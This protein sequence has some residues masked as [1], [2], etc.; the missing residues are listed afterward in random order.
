MKDRPANVRH[1]A[2][3]A[4]TVRHGSLTQAARAVNLT[5]PALSQ[6]ISALEAS[7]DVTLFKRGTAGMIPTE[8]ALQLASRAEV[9]IEHIGSSRVTGTQMRAFL[10]VART[11]SYAAAGKST[12]LTS[13]S[14]H[15]AIADLSVALG[16]NL[17]TRNGKNIM[18]TAAG[19]RRARS[20]GLAASELRAGL[21]EVAAW[22]GKAGARI[23]VGAMP[24]CRARWLP[25]TIAQFTQTHPEVDLVIHEAAY[26]ELV[27]P[28]RHGEIDLILGAL[29]DPAEAE[30]LR[31]EPLFRDRP[32]IIMG[33]GH[34]LLT[35]DDPYAH[36]LDYPWIMPRTGTP[37]RGYWEAMIRAHGQQPPHVAI[38]CGSVMMIRQLLMTGSGLSL[39]SPDQVGVELEA[40]ILMAIPPPVAVERTI[41]ITI[42]DGWRPT[43]AQTALLEILRERGGRGSVPS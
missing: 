6:A 29:R 8:P 10:A 33:K 13:A 34:P 42:R 30:G 28:L 31:Q 11:G 41:G 7:L 19:E 1:F 12:G 4:A 16:Q 9:A 18:L 2:A 5:Q 20:F 25:E 15:R 39:L 21:A 17:L 37:L 27:G 22:R 26:A 40:G 24:L 32:V 23:A 43:A 35:R 14:L 36:L 3:L 38:E